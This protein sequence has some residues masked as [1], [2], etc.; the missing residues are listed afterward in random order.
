MLVVI[1]I[2]CQSGYAMRAHQQNGGWAWRLT[3]PCGLIAHG[4]REGSRE[5]V[6]NTLQQIASRHARPNYSRRAWNTGIAAKRSKER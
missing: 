1:E 6:V 5:D 3:G 4:W 2:P